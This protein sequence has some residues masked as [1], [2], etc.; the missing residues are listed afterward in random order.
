MIT[1]KDNNNKWLQLFIKY[2]RY[3]YSKEE[4]SSNNKIYNLQI[5]YTNGIKLV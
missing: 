3:I 5:V 2:T 4:F 1:F